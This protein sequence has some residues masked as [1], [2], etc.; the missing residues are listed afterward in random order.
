LHWLRPP[1]HWEPAVSDGGDEVGLSIEAGPVTDLFVSP[2]GAAPQLNAPGLVGSPDPH[3]QFSALVEVEFASTFDAGVLA[4]WAHE[5]SWAKLCFEYSPAG[6]PMVV[7]VV[8]RGLSD[9]A[10]SVEVEGSKV[11]LRISGLGAGRYAFHAATDG[12]HWN[13]VRHFALDPGAQP[14]QVGFL[15][16]SPTGEGCR[17]SFSQVRYLPE[18]LDDLRGGV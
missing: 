16:Q 1:A 6:Q 13:L 5:G 10:N 15:A 2:D 8:T 4:L 17:V 18:Q 14:M 7:S 12:V 9:D 11:W 3:F